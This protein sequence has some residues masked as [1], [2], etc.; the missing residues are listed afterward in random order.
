MWP[1]ITPLNV[2][3]L[4]YGVWALYV[5]HER[6]LAEEVSRAQQGPDLESV[7]T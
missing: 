6:Q 3:D 4:T 5:E 2:W 7:R 1:G